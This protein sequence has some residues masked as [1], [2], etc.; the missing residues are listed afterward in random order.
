MMEGDL[1]E[2]TKRIRAMV[3]VMGSSQRLWVEF[4]GPASGIIGPFGFLTVMLSF[5]MRRSS[6]ICVF[7]PTIAVRGVEWRDCGET[8]LAKLLKW[9]RS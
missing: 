5:E 1:Q 2:A 4:I 9:V 6:R 3:Y 8:R 7:F